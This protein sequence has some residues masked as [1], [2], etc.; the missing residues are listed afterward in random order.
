VV[1]LLP[2]IA[3]AIAI[4]IALAPVRRA[5]R[6]VFLYVKLIKFSLTA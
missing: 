5:G 1:S 4:A 6:A 3:I 2:A